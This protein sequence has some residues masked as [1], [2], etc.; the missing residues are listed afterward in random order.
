MVSERVT[1]AEGIS[2]ITLRRSGIL[3]APMLRAVIAQGALDVVNFSFGASRVAFFC[4]DVFELVPL[5]E[6]SFQSGL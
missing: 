2:P 1:G 6:C 3:V 4:G 5:L